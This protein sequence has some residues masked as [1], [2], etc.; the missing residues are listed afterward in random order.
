MKLRARWSYDAWVLLGVT[1]LVMAGIP[2][3]AVCVSTSFAQD[4]SSNG[5]A[6]MQAV[7]TQSGCV[8]RTV[9]VRAYLENFLF[10]C[11]SG[12]PSPSGCIN[13]NSSANTSVTL[14][15][16]VC[17]YVQGQSR[18]HYAQ[19]GAGAVNLPNRSPVLYAGD[20]AAIE[21]ANQGPDYYWNGIE[22]VYAPGS[23]IVI[24]TGQGAQYRFTSVDNGVRFDIDG[25]GI[26]EQIAWTEP[27]SDVAFL[28]LDRDGDGF[29]TSGR[30]LFGNHTVPGVADGFTALARTNMET[31][32]NIP[33]ASVSSDDPLFARLLLWRD[34][35]HNGVS[36]PSE[37]QPASAVLSDIGLGFELHH[38]KDGFGNEFRYRGWVHIRTAPGRN[39]AEEIPEQQQRKR[40]V[41][42]VFFTIQR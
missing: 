39:R 36:E 41:Y 13:N 40:F 8:N 42:D 16:N 18:H 31:N 1:V 37:L 23:P 38:R 28:V 20:C 21:C 25:D 19:S 6:R 33:R 11:L 7:T 15:H 34:R 27:D 22:C 10:T 12:S 9:Y 4:Q 32:R 29:I 17:G 26:T 14:N 5:S 30:E 2:V 3:L 35:N 24:A